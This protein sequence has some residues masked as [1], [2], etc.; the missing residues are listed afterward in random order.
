MSSIRPPSAQTARLK[1]CP[2]PAGRTFGLPL[3]R[4]CTY[5]CGTSETPGKGCELKFE[6]LGLCGD[7]RRGTALTYEKSSYFG[8]FPL[9][10]WE[11]ERPFSTAP[12][13]PDPNVCPDLPHRWSW[14]PRAGVDSKSPCPPSSTKRPPWSV[15]HTTQSNTENTT[16]L[17]SA[18]SL[19][20]D[21]RPLPPFLALC[22]APQSL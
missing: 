1:L 4:A 6:S 20:V 14:A 16:R 5:T 15:P 12:G 3:T 13:S 2:R 10:D 7:D 18:R 9:S 19:T 22:S 8:T 11:S 21:S 17:L